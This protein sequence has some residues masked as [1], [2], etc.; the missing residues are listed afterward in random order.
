[1]CKAP[2]ASD[3]RGSGTPQLDESPVQSSRGPWEASPHARPRPSHLRGNGNPQAAV[4][5]D[6]LGAPDSS[7]RAWADLTVTLGRAGPRL[8]EAHSQGLSSRADSDG[9]ERRAG[10]GAA[11]APPAP[12]ASPEVTWEP[13]VGCARGESVVT[14]WPIGQ[15]APALGF[16]RTH[17]WGAEGTFISR[18]LGLHRHPGSPARPGWSRL[19]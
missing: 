4:W 17:S 9:L 15:R 1:M 2:R 10:S 3:G 11:P 14:G 16:R 19:W 5:L 8:S 12:P 13:A 6:Q 18:E 7:R